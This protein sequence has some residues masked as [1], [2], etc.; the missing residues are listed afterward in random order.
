MISSVSHSSSHQGRVLVPG[1]KSASHR[2]LILSSLA[3]GFSSIY[4]INEGADVK[5]TAEALR[6]MGATISPVGR[7]VTVE[8][9]SVGLHASAVPL[10]FGN[11][12]TGMRLVAGLVCGI[13]GNHVLV[14]DGSLM[15][16][17]MKR[18]GDPLRQMGAE[19][20]GEGESE[21]A[22]LRISGRRPLH[23]VDFHVPV[24]SAQVKSAILLAGLNADSPSTVHEAIRTRTTT[25][26]ML[27]QSGIVVESADGTAGRSVTVHPG[28]PNPHEWKIPGDPSQAAFFVVLGLISQKGDIEVPHV[29]LSP[30]RRGFIDVLLRMGGKIEVDAESGTINSCSS[31]LV[32][33]D[34]W[35]HEIPSVDEVPILVVAAAAATGC[36]K[37]IHM[38]ELRHKE[39]DRF[40]GAVELA[41][42]LGC[43][44]TVDGDSFFVEG[45]GSARRFKTFTINA[46][47]DH[48]FVMS[49]AIAGSAGSGA[50]IEGS[51]T[52]TSSY[53]GFFSD[54]ESCAG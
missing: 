42:S 26:E 1:D 39:S 29:D 36:T 21:T 4:G 34:V 11:S 7:E 20:S 33:T 49:A 14:G 22:P 41:R 43:T 37:F 32:S 23:A 10:D 40:A 15:R 8:G 44:V 52:V 31:S 47:L 25:E 9:P 45:L 28:R 38:D 46:R 2:A 17:P 27:V 30:E 19:F 5:A 12:G 6:H 50:T 18:I 51:D 35:S 54:L 48:R 3:S 16:R 13:P 24:P 53:P